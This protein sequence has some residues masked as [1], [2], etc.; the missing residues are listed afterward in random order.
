MPINYSSIPAD[1]FLKSIDTLINNGQIILIQL[2]TNLKVIG[3]SKGVPSCFGYSNMEF[4]EINLDKLFKDSSYK[5]FKGTCDFLPDMAHLNVPNLTL[6][7]KDESYLLMD[8]T[9]TSV[10]D[11]H[12]DI[13]QILCVFNNKTPLYNMEFQ[14]Q[15]QK[16]LLYSILFNAKIFL[17]V[18]DEEG[19]IN[20]SIG[21][22]LRSLGIQGSELEGERFHQQFP[23]LRE[24]FAAA[25]QGQ[26]SE[27]QFHREKDDAVYAF[28]NWLFPSHT[29]KN[30]FIHIA[31]DVSDKITAEQSQLESKAK[32][33]FLANMSHEIRTPMNGII[34]ITEQLLERAT[35]EEDLEDLKIIQGC[36]ET[37]VNIINDILDLSKIESGK[38]SLEMIPFNLLDSI[39]TISALLETPAKN[40]DLEFIVEIDPQVPTNVIGDPTR[41]K[42]VML[43]LLGNAV[44][45]TSKGFVKFEV[46]LIDHT[47]DDVLIKFAVKDSGIGIKNEKIEKIFEA[48]SQADSSTTRKFG[49]TGLGL[50]ISKNLVE[51]M[52]SQL[53]IVSIFGEGSTFYF[54]LPT[55]EVKVKDKSKSLETSKHVVHNGDIL[56]CEDNPINQ[57]VVQKLF[58]ATDVNLTMAA[59]GEE[60]LNLCKTNKYDVI[61]MDMKMPVMGGIESTQLI[62][63]ESKNRTTPIIA[64]TA[65]A[66]VEDKNACF[67][68]GMNDFLSKPIKKDK[69]LSILNRWLHSN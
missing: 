40:K 50:A 54:H 15:E 18:M 13:K 44:K 67:D 10:K 66:M 63:Q 3:Y 64:L 65:N 21:S 45:F 53:K 39:K 35:T 48:F 46:K 31:F 59:N 6:Y 55:K 41:I 32:S 19:Y 25:Q 4:D 42:Q 37:L 17:N 57:K 22:G 1:K 62:R 29:K 34:A 52:N 23:E 27:N 47:Q 58:S 26:I 56:V 33:E 16:Q 7:K 11:E 38:L 69:L 12:G 61:F 8:V 68:A 24:S 9:I 20:R 43:N 5:E 28:Q 30:E 60:G 51:M 2:D 36:G 14:Y 49:G